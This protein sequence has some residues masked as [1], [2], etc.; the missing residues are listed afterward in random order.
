[1]KISSTSLHYRFNAKVQSDKFTDKAER[2]RFTTCSYIRTSLYSVVQAL[3]FTFVAFL[4][5]FLV[6]WVVGSAIWVPIS[7][8]FLNGTPV[9][10]ALAAAAVFWVLVGI[11][12][13]VM[14]F[15]FIN[16]RYIAPVLKE[17]NVFI[18]AIKDNHN[19]F[20]TRVEVV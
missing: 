14:T 11:A 6:L 1:M 7:I 15:K 18:Q 13:A 17:P 8:F 19:K 9:E 12:L 5:S 20:C 2:G 16:A 10:S 4:A 3:W